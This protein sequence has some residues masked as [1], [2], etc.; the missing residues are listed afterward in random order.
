M[1]F[2]GRRTQTATYW[3]TPVADGYGGHTFTAPASITVRWEERT[4]RFVNPQGEP[5]YSKAV[6]ILGQDVTVGG[7]L[8]LGTSTEAHPSDVSGAYRIRAFEKVPN[9]NG[10]AYQRT[11]YL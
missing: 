10:T 9:V 1:S 8:Y 5:E 7:F 4:E 3:A 2:T 11:A 6:V